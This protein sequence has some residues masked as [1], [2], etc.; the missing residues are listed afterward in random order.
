M[1]GHTRLSLSLSVRACAR[2]CVC[3]CVRVCVCVCLRR[4]CV[5]MH[6]YAHTNI[7]VCQSVQTTSN[8]YSFQVL[9]S[10]RQHPG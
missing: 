7:E 1:G 9:H 2:V 6:V 3:V 8:L 4:V 5:S 10:F